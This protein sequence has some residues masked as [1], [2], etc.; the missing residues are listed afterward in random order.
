MPT[1]MRAGAPLYYEVHGT[2]Y[3]VF[4]I[5]GGGGNTM[6][7]FQQIAFFKER[8]R[9][10]PVDLRGF[11]NS[12]WPTEKFDPGYYPDDMRAIMDAEGIKTAAFVCQSLGAWAGLPIAVYTPERVSCLF[13]NGS[14]TPAY[15]EQN[16]QLMERAN[17]IFM[18]KEFS[19]GEGVGWNRATLSTRPDLVFLY[20]QM[21][22]LNPPNLDPINM[23]AENVK[24]YPAAFKG[25]KVPTML[26]GGAHDDFLIP[27]SHIHSASLIPGCTTHTFPDSGHS[28]YFEHA[29]EFNAVAAEFLG[30]HVPA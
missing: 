25:Y 6:A 3:P 8:Y 5:H 12:T 9:C 19:R 1:I 23:R 16:W 18:S 22:L 26:C 17:P 29:G 7:W 21:K 13:M 24:V 28:A 20:S 15:S 30:R 14:P 4:F 27:G 2:G 10:I 11:K